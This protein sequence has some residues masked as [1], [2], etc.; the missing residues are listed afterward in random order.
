[1]AFSLEYNRTS[2]SGSDTDVS[3]KLFLYYR[4]VL[5]TALARY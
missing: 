4:P 1:M 5:M 3:P 2:T